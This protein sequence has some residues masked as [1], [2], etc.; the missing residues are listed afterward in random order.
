MLASETGMTHANYPK[1]SMCSGI[2]SQVFTKLH[3][4]T[5]TTDERDGVLILTPEGRKKGKSTTLGMAQV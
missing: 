3:N 1:F 5:K 4:L 2:E